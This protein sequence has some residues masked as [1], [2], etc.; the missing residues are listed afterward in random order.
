M[1]LS[2]VSV[3]RPVFATVI[4]LLLVAFGIIS[5]MEL[6]L[7]EYPDTSPPVVS[8]STSYP[9]A[10]AEIVEQQITQL[11]EDQING[12]EGV[13]SINSSSS[14]GSSRVS[15]EFEVGR[16][17]D[18][19]AN[20]IRDKISRITRALP[21]DVEPPQ[22]AKADA[23]GR[24][25]AFF[26]LTSTQMSFLELNDYAER[27]IV[28]QFAVIDGVANVS[29]RGTGGYA[30]R[31]WLDRVKL[32]A[33]GL[34]VTDVES[35]LRRQNLELPAGRVDSIDREFTVR[36]DRVYQT[37]EDFA[38]LVIARGADGHQVT[39]GEV[40]RVELG[41]AS[42]RSI[43]QGNGT[44]AVGLGLVKQS[45]ANSLTVLREATALIER[46][47]AT[48]PDHMSLVLSNSDA[49]FIE[50]AISSVYSTIFMTVVLVSLVIYMFLGS[51]RSMLIPA[52][53]IPVCLLAAF[54]VLLAFGLT[55]NLITLLAMVL[56]V[57]LIVDDSIVVLENIQRRVEA[58]EPPLLA[59]FNGSRQVA[60]AVIATTAV[61]IAV[62]VP[63]V[64]MDGNMGILFYELAITVGGAVIFST[65][66][67]LSLTPMMASKLLNTHAH[68]SFL[69][70]Q[71]DRFFRWLQR[72]YHNA[73]EVCLRLRYAVAASLVLIGIAVYFLW[74]QVPSE[75]APQE[76]QGVM[77]VRMAGPEG[78]SMSY[79]Q[80]KTNA[81][82]D[83]L[84]PYLERGEVSSVVTMLPGWGGGGG[85]NSGMSIIALP[86][87][88]ER[89][90]PTTDI[91]SE[92]MTEWRSIPGLETMMF[93][94]SGL[95]RGGGGQPVQFVIGGRSYEELA[96]WRDMLIQRGEASGM[97]TRMTSDYEETRP[98]L[99][100]T[101]DKVRAADLGVSIQAI[102]RTL[103]AM[104][105][106]SR[107]TTF[108]DAGEEY[109][110]ILQAEETQ[111]ASPDDLT[112]IYVR[113]EGT[114]QLIPMSNLISVENTSAAN[115]LNRYNRVRAITLSAGLQPGVSLDEALA[116]LENL[117]LTE[118]PDYAQI[119][120]KGESLELKEASG[121]L[122][123]IF[124]MSLLVVFL[125][126]AAQ[127]ESF[128]HPLVIMTTVPLA[129]FGALIGLLLTDGT[130]NIYTNIGL[131]ILVGIA[132]KN[133]ILIVEFANQ[134]RD[135]GKPFR[136]ALV[137][138]CD[139]RLRPVLMTAIS[140]L[141]GALPLILST[142]A[143]S[144]S[145]VLLGTVIFSGVLMTTLM[146]LFIVPVVYDL[147][148]K[149]TS[150]PQAVAQ[151]LGSLQR[152]YA[153]KTDVN[154]SGLDRDDNAHGASGGGEPQ[155]VNQRREDV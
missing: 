2:D 76:D 30:M 82:Q 40:A 66:L 127:F 41:A 60:F 3:K 29:V 105:N 109:D 130:L 63:V 150:S 37:P 121:G 149:N 122:A 32:A 132:S 14:D 101:V 143:G 20:D 59:A 129:I 94:R 26:N 92:L 148:A 97:F 90:K 51:V 125:V 95:V 68:E 17:I 48:L 133:G 13:T 86:D 6:P 57:G 141:M 107:V 46:I 36:V 10:S 154:S 49:E 72:G 11:I 99:T 83:T 65:V 134:L 75:F 31:V 79:M 87:W 119:D 96:Q 74:Q 114:G 69:T 137:T 115:S 44:D 64:F 42:T 155:A 147:L 112:N 153:G 8:V 33:R 102:G 116:F 80:D 91:M 118:L 70:R 23:D 58:G 25:I 124:A 93:M 103:Q 81:I 47:N 111:R 5:F 12:V 16:D 108:I 61:L 152:K 136:E 55:I 146:T 104:M 4:S 1:V 28:D 139:M 71:V 85:V 39:L 77:M 24:P 15:V 78:A 9:G 73:L 38:R 135:E 52:V 145:R 126:L 89:P 62:F 45:N 131:I 110:V 138:A 53:T 113:S 117:V 106:E 18:Q 56:C 21:E 43:F 27:F 35:A 120:Y 67:A 22:I 84:L 144:E 50:N 54:M 123:L 88:A 34:T 7:R 151:M 19:A 142:G 128:V 140:T 98:S 100:I